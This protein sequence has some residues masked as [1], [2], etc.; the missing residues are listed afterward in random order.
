VSAASRFGLCSRKDVA[1]PSAWIRRHGRSCVPIATRST[2]R[3][4]AL[5]FWKRSA[6]AAVPARGCEDPADL[7]HERP[8][9]K[10]WRA[11][12][13]SA[14]SGVR[15]QSAVALHMRVGSSADVILTLPDAE[16]ATQAEE[17]LRSALAMASMRFQR[18]AKETA[19][20]GKS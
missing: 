10:A 12:S 2:P 14:R 3:E 11:S 18:I 9:R 4:T 5:A 6:H 17:Q 19:S 20:S 7:A 1:L 13:Q 16:V 15:T 8:P